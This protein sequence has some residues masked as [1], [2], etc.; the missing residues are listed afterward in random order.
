MFQ[1]YNTGQICQISDVIN[2][3]VYNLNPIIYHE[4]VL[5]NVQELY[6]HQTIHVEE[7]PFQ[8]IEMGPIF[9]NIKSADVLRSE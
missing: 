1:L 4:T 3:M 7:F 9:R 5:T 6:L 8:Y 2:S